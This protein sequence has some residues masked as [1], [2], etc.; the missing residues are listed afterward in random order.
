MLSSWM[1]TKL[2]YFYLSHDSSE[3]NDFEPRASSSQQSLSRNSTKNSNRSPERRSARNTSASTS[4]QRQKS[5]SNKN[6]VEPN[7]GQETSK[8]QGPSTS[9]KQA[10]G[11]AK[12]KA[13]KPTVKSHFKTPLQQIRF[14][15][16]HVENLIP[17]MPFCRL[18][19]EILHSHGDFRMTKDSLDALQEASESYLVGV[20]G[21]AFRLT[22]HRQRVTIQPTDIQLLLYLRGG[23][24]PGVP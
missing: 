14:L 1:F 16:M 10:T 13:K 15:Q 8:N 6:R 12:R 7:R 11:A 22:L 4:Q 9:T 21:D 19:K 24:D 18:V 2:N 3:D 5:T 17:K 23:N 20:F